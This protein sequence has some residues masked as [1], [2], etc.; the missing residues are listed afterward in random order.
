ME[1][2]GK[3]WLRILSAGVVIGLIA[4]V[5]GF[6]CWRLSSTSPSG[7]PAW[8]VPQAAAPGRAWTIWST[9]IETTT[10]QTVTKEV[11]QYSTAQVWLTVDISGTIQ[12]ITPTVRMS[13]DK[14]NWYELHSFGNI[15]ADQALTYTTLTDIGAYLQVHFAISNTVA[16]TPSCWMVVKD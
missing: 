16:V 3:K 15:T 9:A 2:K 10:A 4:A 1:A 5:L 11:G 7:E 14:A 13:P 8:I 12:G 6:V